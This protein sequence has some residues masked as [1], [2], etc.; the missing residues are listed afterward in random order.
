M[1]ADGDTRHDRRD[2][3]NDLV[4]P[5][6]AERTEDDRGDVREDRDAKREGD[7]RARQLMPRSF[8]SQREIVRTYCCVSGYGGTPA[9]CATAPGPAL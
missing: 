7:A 3:V 4:H 2:H 6:P 9:Y 1:K 5:Q 8:S